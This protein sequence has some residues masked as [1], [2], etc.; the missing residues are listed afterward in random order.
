L[1]LFISSSTSTGPQLCDLT[2]IVRCRYCMRPIQRSQLQSHLL[3]NHEFDPEIGLEQYFEPEVGLCYLL[4]SS[5]NVISSFVIMIHI[6]VLVYGM[7]KHAFD[8]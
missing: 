6:M 8:S 2:E 1:L 7:V 5:Q 4:L 3:S